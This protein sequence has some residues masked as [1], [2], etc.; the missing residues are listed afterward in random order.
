MTADESAAKI[1]DILRIDM[2]TNPGHGQT[3]GSL[4]AHWMQA[5]FSVN[6]FNAG[7][8]AAIRS[9]SV[10]VVRDNWVILN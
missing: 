9:G 5:G 6:D 8:D 3:L 7:I 1:A 4:K 2:K 10:S